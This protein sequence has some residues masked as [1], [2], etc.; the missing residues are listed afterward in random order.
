MSNFSLT[1]SNP[2]IRCAYAKSNSIAT[3]AAASRVHN[4][5]DGEFVKKSSQ[6]RD[7]STSGIASAMN[8]TPAQSVGLLR[9]TNNMLR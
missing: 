3:R 6:N 8:N 7:V 5:T 9:V 1:R 4:I 2:S